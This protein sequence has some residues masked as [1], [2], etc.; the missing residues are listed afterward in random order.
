MKK[1]FVV[2]ACPG[3]KN[4]PHAGGKTS[5]YYL[6]KLQNIYNLIIVSAFRNANEYEKVVQ[7]GA[8]AWYIDIYSRNFLTIVSNLF[9]AVISLLTC[10]V[11]WFF[12]SHTFKS[13]IR[14]IALKLKKKGYSP[15]VVIL[16]WTQCGL[17][18][19][20]L[21]RIFPE[22]KYV[23]CEQD[24]S[25][26]AYERKKENSRGV[27]KI[28]Y[29]LQYKVLKHREIS[30][31][32]VADNVIVFNEKDRNLLERTIEFHGNVRVISPYYDNYNFIHR[33]PDPNTIIF[34]G[35]MGRYENYKSVEWFIENVFRKL[36]NIFKFIII[37]SNPDKSLEKYASDRIKI[38]GFVDD[39]SPYFSTALCMVVPLLFGAG[40]KVKILEAFSAGIPVLTND[41]GIEG[42]PAEDSKD[43][44][45]C[46]DA[47]DY[48]EKIF[49]L[50]KQPVVALQMSNSCRHFMT[51]NFNMNYCT[52]ID[53]TIANK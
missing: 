50:S 36:P 51:T 35:A 38:I 42:I 13:N 44:F 25:F 1:V 3:Y 9:H 53:K 49:Y 14:K 23:S 43:Y 20:D 7:N 40:I 26:L 34:Y 28:I 12:C 32:N 48:I 29:S 2:A 19:K 15:D 37:G 39:V 31:M 11:Y 5:Y 21:K 18:I 16:D 27:K 41:I 47:K 6:E 33:N 24:V 46:T 30:A 22:A 45:H 4:V 52:Y 17:L 8:K 10:N